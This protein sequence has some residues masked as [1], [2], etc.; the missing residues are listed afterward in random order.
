MTFS[1]GVFA[2][3]YGAWASVV[4]GAIIAIVWA[5]IALQDPGIIPFIV[6][7]LLFAWFTMP[8]V[9]TG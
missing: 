4:I 6:M 3:V 5:A 8:S 1:L 7:V 2:I 9:K